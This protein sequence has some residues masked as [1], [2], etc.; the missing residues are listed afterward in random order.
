MAATRTAPAPSVSR[1]SGPL[2]SGA[3]DCHSHV[4]GPFERF[5]PLQPSVYDL[6]EAGPSVHAAMRAGL[7]V[8]RGVLVQPA[9]YAN[10]PS[11]LL[12]AIAGSAGALRGV[13]VADADIAEDKLAAWHAGGIRGLRFVEMRAPG[14][15]RYPGSVGFDALIRL[16]PRLRAHGLHAELWATADDLAAHLPALLATGLPLVLDHMASPDIARGV[17]DRTFQTILGLLRH[18]NLWVKLPVCRV[19]KAAPGHADAR[20]FHEAYLAAAPDRLLWG[21]DW[22]YVRMAPAPDAG[23]MLD[24]F[25]EWTPDEAARRR[26]LVDNPAR[27]Y[28]FGHD[29]GAAR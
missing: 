2:P 11:A 21:S 20:P 14:G 7:G 15:S 4:F 3:C 27:L 23:R 29:Q 16:A 26:I 19:S 13:A 1:P 12:D 5:A 9:P 8:A 28:G 25:F 24:L 17:D 6:P 18:G 22:P 10:D